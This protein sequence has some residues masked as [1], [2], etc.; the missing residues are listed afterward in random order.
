MFSSQ[1]DKHELLVYDH[2]TIS[3]SFRKSA[4]N[5]IRDRFTAAYFFRPWADLALRGLCF[6]VTAFAPAH[7]VPR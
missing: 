2:M 3:R 4:L 5:S 1:F 6:V 7:W